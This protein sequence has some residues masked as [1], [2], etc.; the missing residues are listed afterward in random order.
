MRLRAG[1]LF[2]AGRLENVALALLLATALVIWY[3]HRDSFRRLAAL[4][5]PTYCVTCISHPVSCILHLVSV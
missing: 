1:I 2:F 4:A 3:W 5:C